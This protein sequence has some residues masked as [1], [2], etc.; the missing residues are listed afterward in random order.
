MKKIIGWDSWFS[1]DMALVRVM[2]G[3]E[4]TKRIQAAVLEILPSHGHPKSV[5]N[6]LDEIKKLQRGDLAKFAGSQ[7]KGDIAAV[8][9]TLGQIQCQIMPARV[10]NPSTFIQSVWLRVPFF[11][12]VAKASTDKDGSEV[13]DLLMGQPA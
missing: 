10:S 5:E 7:A 11:A 2:T 1:I 13:L 9:E 8:S 3:E 6:A 12:T 4:G